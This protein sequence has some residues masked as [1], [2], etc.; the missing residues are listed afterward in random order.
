MS[1]AGW[2]CWGVSG[3]GWQIWGERG[4][5]G[6]GGG[7]VCVWMFGGKTPRLPP[8]HR[9]SAASAPVFYAWKCPLFPQFSHG[10]SG[11]VGARDR[12]RVG[13][14][15]PGRAAS[16]LGS[17]GLRGRLCTERRGSLRPF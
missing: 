17:F 7:G 1:G 16:P 10:V 9:S 3:S 4:G 11:G 15:T 12:D 6:G 14:D 5:G 2:R 13:V 8:H